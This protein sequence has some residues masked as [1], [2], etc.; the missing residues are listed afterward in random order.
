M[1]SSR[2][3]PSSPRA[4]GS[5]RAIAGPIAP[6]RNRR[7]DFSRRD[8]DA[9]AF[10][11]GVTVSFH[12]LTFDIFSNG[13]S[14]PARSASSSAGAFL[15]WERDAA[16]AALAQ[17]RL[18]GLRA[19]PVPGQIKN[20]RLSDGSPVAPECCWWTPGRHPSWSCEPLRA[21]QHEIVMRGQGPYLR[22]FFRGLSSPRK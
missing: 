14:A 19:V 11:V 20:V 4:T 5:C 16:M 12:E 17:R 9:L 3:Q 6:S 15:G 13:A 10:V 18:S 22:G 2:R 21:R 7:R 1:S 8:G